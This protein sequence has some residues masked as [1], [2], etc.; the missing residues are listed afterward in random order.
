M[1]HTTDQRSELDKIALLFA[2][3][4]RQIHKTFNTAR[5]T[6]GMSNRLSSYPYRIMGLLAQEGALPV[7]EIGSKLDIAKSNVSA[8]VNKQVALGNLERIPGVTDRRVVMIGLTEKGKSEV[9]EAYL[10]M[11][12]VMAE[13]FSRLSSKD[14]KSLTRHLIS[15]GAILE[16]LYIQ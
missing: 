11:I 6:T 7:T 15:I 12:K 13:Y 5:K 9:E 8:C 1:K 4:F 2:E 3:H 14:R 10:A 16:D